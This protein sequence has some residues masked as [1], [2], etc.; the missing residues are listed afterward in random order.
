MRRLFVTDLQR[1]LDVPP[2][3]GVVRSRRPLFPRERFFGRVDVLFDPATGTAETLLIH[4]DSEKSPSLL[5]LDRVR[6]EGDSF[7]LPDALF[8]DA[9]DRIQQSQQSLLSLPVRT[10]SGDELG[11]V[12]DV[13]LLWEQR[14]FHQLVVGGGLLMNLIQGELLLTWD[15][16]L[17]IRKEDIVVK[18]A[19]V[20]HGV[21]E[22]LHAL[23]PSS[24][25]PAGMPS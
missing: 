5:P 7:L 6:I 22:T 12:K 13:V 23:N 2:A 3:S 9:Y 24:G 20:P 11:V 25:L 14:A 18:D 21:L 15:D 1:F 8:G 17:E 4:K 10:R 16:I 19:V